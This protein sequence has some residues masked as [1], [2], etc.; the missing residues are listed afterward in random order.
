MRTGPGG[1]NHGRRELYGYIRSPS[2]PKRQMSHVGDDVVLECVV[3]RAD[4]PE[5]RQVAEQVL[6]PGNSID[7]CVFSATHDTVPD[8]H[9]IFDLLKDRAY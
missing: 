4:I 7:G 5:G 3:R 2:L 6:V 9:I 8:N 1:G